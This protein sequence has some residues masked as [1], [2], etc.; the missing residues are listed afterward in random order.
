MSIFVIFLAA[1]GL[2]VDGFTISFTGGILTKK[3]KLKNA[4]NIGMYFCIV[5][6]SLAALGWFI[7]SRFDGYIAEYSNIFAIGLLIFIG[8]RMIFQYIKERKEKNFEGKELNNKFFPILALLI[9][10]DE[11][12]AGVSFGLFQV[13]VVEVLVILAI[14]FFATS[15]TGILIGRKLGIILKKKA[16]LIGGL[17]FLAIALVNIFT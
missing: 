14:T 9:S 8:L 13:N 17:L 6:T 10:I 12:A 1:L 3:Q 4:F 2:S 7:G 11:L 15:F 16:D 5:Q